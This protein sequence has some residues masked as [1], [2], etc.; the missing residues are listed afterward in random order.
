[1]LSDTKD[2]EVI[3]CVCVE[4]ARALVLEVPEL[5]PEPEPDVPE[6][7]CVWAK[8]PPVVLLLEPRKKR[9]SK[10]VNLVQPVGTDEES[11][12]IMAPAGKVVA[13]TDL[14][15]TRLWYGGSLFPAPLVMFG[16]PCVCELPEV[17]LVP[18]PKVAELPADT[19]AKDSVWV[20]VALPPAVVVVSLIYGKTL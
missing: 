20:C 14:M 18:D 1:M 6:Y 12:S 4:E 16:K 15:A 7:V 13:V 19:F 5:V 11:K 9:L 17:E 2:W 3:W 10:A 8:A